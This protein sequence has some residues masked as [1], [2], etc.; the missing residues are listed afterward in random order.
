ML[1]DAEYFQS[2]IGKLDGAKD[3][4]EYIINIINQKPIAAPHQ[5]TAINTTTTIDIPDT[6]EI[7]IDQGSK[8]S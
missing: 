8:D 4:A 5:A 3:P 6:A 1:R 2:R 7:P